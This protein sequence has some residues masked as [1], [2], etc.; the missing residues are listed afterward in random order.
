MAPVERVA[1]NLEKPVVDDRSYRVIRL[2]NQ[3]EALLVHDPNTDKASASVNVNV[4]NF[5]DDDDLPGIA[6][7][8]EHALF[9]GTEKYPKEN[10]YNQYL[11]AHSGYSNAYTAAT[12]TNYYFEVAATTNTPKST[13]NTTPSTPAVP[14]DEP[15]TDG[16]SKLSVPTPASSA[17]TSSTDLV[18]PLYGALDRFAQFFIAPLFL[19][20]TLDR[21]L[22]AV[23]SENKKNLQSDAW[24]LMQLN[25]SLSNPKHPYHHFSTGNL[26]TLRDGPQSRGVDVRAEFMRFHKTHYSANRMKLVVLGQEPLDV[27]EEW[28]AELFA[29]VE[30]K[31]L[32]KLRWDDVEPF[33][34]EDMG[35]QVFAKPVMDTRSLDIYFRYQDEE[36]MFESQ[37]SRYISHLIG[38]EGPGSILA[39]IKAKGWAHELSA[40]SMAVCSGSAFFTISVRL[41]EDGLANYQEVT[42]VIFQYISL[43]KQQ[44]PEKWVFDEMKNLAEVDFKFKQ[45][46]PASR[47]ASSL[48]SVMQRPYPRERLLSA[49]S[50]ML[51]FEPEL[52]TRGLECFRADNFNIELVSQ[53]Y[54]GNWD[55]KEKWYGTEYKLE[56]IP[57][58]VLAEIGHILE[59][60]SDRPAELHMP[61][62]NEFVPTRL[63]VEKKDIIVPAKKPTLIRNDHQFRVWHKKD[64]TFWVPKGSIDITLRTPLVYTSPGTNVT[65]R[66]F[67]ELVRDSLSDYSYDAELAGLDYSL[68]SSVFGLE[69]SVSG[70]NDKMAVLLEKVLVSMR[71]LKVKPDR[72][73]VVKERM[74]KAFW[75]AEYQLPYYQVGNFT[76]YLTAE[77]AWINEQLAAELE[78]IEAEDVASFFPQLLRQTHV[79]VLGHGN[80]YKEDLLKMTDLVESTIKARPLPQS[81]WHV[82]RNM[83]IPPGSNYIYE[84]TLKDPANVNNC[85]EYYLFV[86]SIAEPLLRAKSLLFGQLTSE[87]AFDQLRTQEQLG[88]VVWSGAR[89]AATTLGYRVI[90]QSD[91]TNQYLESRIDAFLTR[92]AETLNSMTEE[93]FESHKRSIINK[94]L[95]KL[96]NLNSETSRYWSH[97]GSEYFDFV[98]HE[99]DA[100]TLDT[101]TKSD[102]IEFYRQYID[103]QSPTRAKL[104]IYMNAQ[105]TSHKATP[106]QNAKLAEQLANIL[107]SAEIEFDIEKLK[108]SFE[109]V[110]ISANTKDEVAGKFKAFLETEVKTSSEKVASVIGPATNALE[111]LLQGLS[112][113]SS[114]D[115]DAVPEVVI[116]GTS[117]GIAK[118]VPEPTYITNVPEFKAGLPASAAPVP[119]VDLSEFEDFDPKL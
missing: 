51:N 80:L 72:F 63:D 4:G 26:Q 65:S 95:E 20:S 46:S 91:R 53:T 39:Y 8:V 94:R 112:G 82:R 71:D 57:S 102:M 117:N 110:E 90:I 49:S 109:G 104:S 100:E 29:D 61:H 62:K 92:Y 15:L 119:I 36:F 10:A 111:E 38:H 56:K 24:R 84:K 27:L 70:Y 76:R 42:K 107:T 108:A 113:K 116:N 83:I 17:A 99:K 40:G 33:A 73:K 93:E 105:S 35:R 66:L 75:N 13:Q 1:E 45:K 89:Y 85:I 54:P 115:N 55:S 16:L 101:L 67:C 32:P 50:C 48:S 103:P 9:M 31:N 25:K 79:E 106:E 88:Y 43:I 28:V 68:S 59:S 11:A 47:F 96:K 2:P 21:E 81:Q 77:K 12:E 41:T 5:S 64:D 7:A 14:A 34:P 78:H 58:D 3:L 86:G 6:H 30:N 97:I 52:I 114:S 18:P 44:P 118:S 74:S 87:P 60:P 98:Q 37:P 69:V 23:D 22:R 19:E